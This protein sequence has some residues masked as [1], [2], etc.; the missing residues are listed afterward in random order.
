MLIYYS[1]IPV[2]QL[3]HLANHVCK[4]IKVLNKKTLQPKTNTVVG[5]YSDIII[6]STLAPVEHDLKPHFHRLNS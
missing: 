3:Y 1:Y 4:P 2:V 5:M 6:M